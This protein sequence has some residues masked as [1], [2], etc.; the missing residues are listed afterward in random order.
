M[1]NHHDILLRNLLS[2]RTVEDEAPEPAG[3]RTVLTGRTQVPPDAQNDVS[4]DNPS[5]HTTVDNREHEDK[6]NSM[7]GQPA[8]N[9]TIPYY[10]QRDDRLVSLS[11][12]GHT[13]QKNPLL[14][15]GLAGLLGWV[16]IRYRS[17]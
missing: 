16:V 10:G 2:Y 17:S 5:R 14:M 7:R 11:D 1:A 12:I 8:G 9:V 15:L 4:D 6:H 13:L 3:R